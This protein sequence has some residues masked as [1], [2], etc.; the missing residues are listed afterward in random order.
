MDINNLIF[1]HKILSPT[2][3]LFLWSLFSQERTIFHTFPPDIDQRVEDTRIRLLTVFVD[4][5]LL[6][7]SLLQE[8]N[9]SLGLF[10]EEYSWF[11]LKSYLASLLVKNVILGRGF[12]HDIRD[13]TSCH[14]TNG[15]WR[16]CSCNN[17][18]ASSLD[19]N[20]ISIIVILG[21]KDK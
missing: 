4:V 20:F 10:P 3:R 15:C 7:F 13:L 17:I 14:V 16:R 9:L 2:F 8:M 12:T 18:L 6:L 5:F 1:S 19:F 11:L 21:W